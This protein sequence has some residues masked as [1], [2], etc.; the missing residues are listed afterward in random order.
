MSYAGLR[1]EKIVAETIQN[2]QARY[3][4]PAMLRITREDGCG[5]APRRHALPRAAQA[6]ADSRSAGP[7]ALT[8]SCGSGALRA[9]NSTS[10]PLRVIRID[11]A[12]NCDVLDCVREPLSKALLLRVVV[13][14]EAFIAQVGTRNEVVLRWAHGE[15]LA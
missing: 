4:P 2:W 11:A 13:G 8:R 7:A 6:C 5:C 12:R 1:Q 9:G 14:A 3:D 15:V 10:T